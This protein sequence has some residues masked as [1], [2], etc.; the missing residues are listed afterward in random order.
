[1][2]EKS[3]S[4]TLQLRRGRRRPGAAVHNASLRMRALSSKTGP[5][6][7]IVPL[8]LAL[9]PLWTVG[10]LL[11]GLWTP[12][13]PR[14]ADIAW[15]M[16]WQHHWALPQLAGRP[17]LEQPPLSY[18]A[19]AL[20]VRAFGDSP[21]ALRAPNLVYAVILALAMGWLGFTLD[22]APAAFVAALTAGSAITAFR[23]SMWLAP[24][25]C[26]LAAC[27]VALLGAYLGYT[28]PRGRRKLYGYLL[29]HAGAAA[30]FMAKSAVGWLVPGLTLLS[31]TAWERRWQE[32]RRGE[33]YAGFLLQAAV[34]GP[35]LLAVAHSAHGAHALRVMFWY[36][37]AGRF[38]KIA[39]PTAYQYTN[40]H[41]NSFG[42]YFLQ[43]PVYLLPWS[44]LAAAAARRAWHRARLPEAPGTRWRFAVCASLPWLVLLSLAATARDVY[45]APALLGFSLLIAL[46]ASEAQRLAGTPLTA[47]RWTRWTVAVISTVFTATAIAV[48]AIHWRAPPRALTTLGLAAAGLTATALALRRSAQMQRSGRIIE[49]VGWT[50][51]AYAAAFCLSALAV[52]PTIDRWQ[53]LSALARRIH[54][55]TLHQPLA[56]LNPDETTVAMLD[57]GLQTRFT[58][59]DVPA[60]AAGSAVSGWFA[61]HGPEARVLVLLPG[62]ANGPF[63][64]LL[65]AL[66]LWRAPG[67]GE[68]GRLQASGAALIAHRYHL[69]QGRRYALLAPPG[70]AAGG[71]VGRARG[72]AW[73]KR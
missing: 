33:L 26:L 9:A 54:A 71:T 17:F 31:L 29:M 50:Y 72:M 24:D 7:W 47:L 37:L 35:W 62:H 30:G 58:R 41:H 52:F 16:S 73:R 59:L 70:D 6:R 36:N 69:P 27:A 44:A 12:D 66:G 51:G 56:L 61:A 55:Q 13:E 5:G 19:A 43:L 1:M 68:A 64:P 42:K 23:V 15:R 63:T 32:L 45:A 46:W 3:H 53:D 4:D 11:R 48:A 18:W 22:G 57:H 67:D 34:I 25:A 49:S 14:V 2:A 10:A 21:D 8:L 65:R 60:R 39:A 28:A 40:A 38:M 20:A